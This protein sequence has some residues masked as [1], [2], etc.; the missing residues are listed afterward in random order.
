MRKKLSIQLL[1]ALAL[2]VFGTVTMLGW[3]LRIV[4]IVQFRPDYIGI[5]FNTGLCFSLTGIAL[6]LAALKSRQTTRAQ[7]AIGWTVITIALISLLENVLDS[8]LLVDLPSLHSWLQD[9]NPHPGRMAINTCIGFVLAGVVIISM[10]RVQS[11]A[12]GGVVLIATF[13]VFILGI[14][15]I[16]GRFLDIDLIYPEIRTVRMAAQTAVAMIVLAIGLW[17]TWRHDDWYRTQRYFKDDEKTGYMSA[18]ILSATALTAGIVGFAIQ[19][20]MLETALSESLA[21]RLKSHSALFHAEVNQAVKHGDHTSMHT[22]LI[23]LVRASNMRG[24][25]IDAEKLKARIGQNLLAEGFHRIAVYDNSNREVLRAGRIQPKVQIEKQLIP[26]APAS[27]RWD[28]MLLLNTRSAIRENGRTIGALEIEQALPLF[29][30]QLARLEGFGATGEMGICF[31]HDDGIRCFPQGRNPST[32]TFV[33]VSPTGKLT[34]MGHALEGRSGIFTG[35]DYR[36]SDVIAAYAP[37]TATG[38]AIVIKQDAQELYQPIR[39]QL[40]WYF[41]LLAIL[42]AGGA[43]M[44][45]SEVKPLVSRLLLSE[46]MAKE[47]E[48]H[49][50]TVVETA[51]EGIITIN[52]DGTIE[53]FNRAASRIFGYQPDE[54]IGQKITTLMPP[55]F[56]SLHRDGM[57][58]YLQ[59]GGAKH[60]GKRSVELPGLHKD[61]RTV[62]LEMAINETSINGR[63]VMVGIVQDITDRKKAELALQESEARSREIAETLGEGVF[64]T[65]SKGMIIFSNPAAQ[66]LLGWTGEEMLG[67]HS[68]LLFR[69]TREDDSDFL[70]D[71]CDFDKVLSSGESFRGHDETFW[72]KDG[73]LLP[74]SVNSTAIFRNGQVTGAVVA[75]H[76][77]IERK[78][79]QARMEHLA[80]FDILTD[81]PNRMLLHDRLQQALANAIR[82]K[83]R[84]AVMFIDLDDFKPVNDTLGHD[85]GD[86]LL[87]QVAQR[88]CGCLRGSDTVARVGGDEFIVLLPVIESEGDAIRVAGKILGALKQAFVLGSHTIHISCSIGIALYPEHGTELEH[89]MKNADEAMYR[90]KESGGSSIMSYSQ[91]EN[92]LPQETLF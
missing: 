28:G 57:Q 27:L 12:A 78:K 66:Q 45:R 48:L 85:V 42:V 18:T 11:R 31:S 56:R 36:G 72:R 67:R 59:T 91:L 14:A 65:D 9:L 50:R 52:E 30:A 81:L 16:A 34:P 70:D 69:Q 26:S 75:F 43:F 86:L 84:V 5:V 89:L 44:L 54:A 21:A 35:A 87:Q 7:I 88:L 92:S 62:P 2:A 74:V 46:Q 68:R 17:A 10:P 23:R 22:D 33:R 49:V 19:Q 29:G 73:A 41:P 51:G 1:L 90:A 71:S 53:S 40:N 64:V 58:H 15:G 6:V 37:L 24:A 4:P 47:R 3:V 39:R 25:S 79:N 82:N 60:V 20:E 38:L 61:G 76:D 77:I 32:H 13:I 63:R 80:H 83:I 55:E 8:N